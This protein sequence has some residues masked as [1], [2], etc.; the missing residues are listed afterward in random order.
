MVSKLKLQE[1]GGDAILNGN[2][3]KDSVENAETNYN[4]M[5]AHLDLK[6][7]IGVTKFSVGFVIR[8]LQGKDD[9]WD[10]LM[11]KRKL[12]RIVITQISGIGYLSYIYRIQFHFEDISQ[13]F[14]A[15]LKVPT[16]MHIPTVNPLADD[17][18]LTDF[19]VK[20][21][22]RHDKE[23]Y[24]YENFAKRIKHV[25]VAA[26]YNARTSFSTDSLENACV[27]MEDLGIYGVMPSVPV[28]LT[29]LQVEGLI[30]AIAEIH[31]IS[32]SVPNSAEL[33]EKL[34]FT[35]SLDQEDGQAKKCGC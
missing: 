14:S 32:L 11:A 35:S 31:A 3:E 6:Q 22:E 2:S 30:K 15:I 24:F 18:F 13:P 34:R 9:K 10:Q 19:A 33:I 16:V 29:K 12:Q 4:G 27:L 28:G 23:I 26:M 17:V 1:N 7:K 20:L 8:S 5:V 25:K 21:A